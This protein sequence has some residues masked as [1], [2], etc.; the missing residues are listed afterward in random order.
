MP[1]IIAGLKENILEA[2]KAQLFSKG[3]SN[4]TLRGVAKECGIAVGTIYNYFPGKEDLIGAIIAVDWLI[5]LNK[6]QTGSAEAQSV[7]AG[8]D[9]VYNAIVDFTNLYEAVWADYVMT[10]SAP[11]RYNERHAMLRGQLETVLRDLLTRH[12]KKGD[13]SF[14]PLL[15]ETVLCA[16]VQRDIEQSQ[17]SEIIKRIFI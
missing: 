2:A 1:K 9:A 12:G 8:V 13:D 17:L 3:Y 16:A 15:A 14:V 11:S 7:Q 5:A 6:M 10:G 4:M